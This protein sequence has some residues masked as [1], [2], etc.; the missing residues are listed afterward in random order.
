M[1]LAVIAVAL[2]LS[3]SQSGHDTHDGASHATHQPTAQADAAIGKN[4][5]QRICKRSP[6]QR[7]E[8]RLKKSSAICKTRAEWNAESQPANTPPKADASPVTQPSAH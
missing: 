5:N 7:T 1:N 8:T 3:P 6:D 4:P 2:L